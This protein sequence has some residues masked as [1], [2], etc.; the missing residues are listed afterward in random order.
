MQKEEGCQGKNGE[1]NPYE[2]FIYSWQNSSILIIQTPFMMVGAEH[3]H[4]LKDI[5][6]IYK[7]P[8]LV[9]CEEF[10]KAN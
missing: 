3:T 1:M 9:D 6:L 8:A 7:Y 2:T 5:R 4:T 10:M